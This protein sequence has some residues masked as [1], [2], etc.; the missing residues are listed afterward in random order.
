[1]RRHVEVYGRSLS[2]PVAF[3]IM[4]EVLEA[5]AYAHA[6]IDQNGQRAEIV[7]RD[8]APGNVLL[9]FRGEVKLSDFG[10]A[11]ADGRVSKTELGTLKGNACF[12]SPEQARGEAVD[13][14]SD[15]FSAGAVLYYCLTAQFLY[16]DDQVM[17]KRLLRAA[18]GPALAEFS[19]IDQIPPLAANAIRRAVAPNQDDRYQ[20]AQEFARDLIGHYTGGRSELADLMNEL[21]PQETRVPQ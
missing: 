15:V 8:V 14:R 7:H 12:M 17:F 20:S 1:M 16:S 19:Q 10:I 11:K 9:S 18:A 21:F 2:V 5:L 13:G 6:R 4:Q 3:Y